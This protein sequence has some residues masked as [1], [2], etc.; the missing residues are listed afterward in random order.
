MSKL[1]KI[2]L[3]QLQRYQRGMAEDLAVQTQDFD[4]GVSSI[5]GEIERYSGIDN[6]ESID[7]VA[8][9]FFMLRE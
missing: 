2:T 9:K 3:D 8:Q 6:L 5:T 4:A 1:S 7:E